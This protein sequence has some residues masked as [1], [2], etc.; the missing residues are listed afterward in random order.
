MDRWLRVM[1]RIDAHWIGDAIG[2]V[3]LFAGL[4]GCLFLG[5]AWGFE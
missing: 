5:F 3:C 2:A 4:W 1:A